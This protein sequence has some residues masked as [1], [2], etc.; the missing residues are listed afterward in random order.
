MNCNEEVIIKVLGKL[1]LTFPELEIDLPRQRKLREVLADVL[2]DYDVLTRETSLIVSDIEEKV[3]YFLSSKKLDGLSPRTLKNYRNILLKF[4]SLMKKP[5]STITTNDMRRYLAFTSQYKAGE[6][7]KEKKETSRN[8]E[9]SNLK[10][11][12]AWLQDEE[13]ILK[14]PMKKIK[15]TKV[16]K[17]LRHALSEEEV[18]ILRQA[19]KTIRE[20]S[21]LEFLL[22]TG[23]RLSEVVGVNK[24]DINWH[25]MSLSVIG[26]GNKERVVYFSPKTKILLLKYLETRKGDNEA[27]FVSDRRPHQRLGGRAIQRELKNIALRTNLDKSVFSHLM[28]HCFGSHKLNAGM[29]L[30]VLQELM[31]HESPETT[32]VYSKVSKENVKYEYKK[33]M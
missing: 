18:E 28:R 22:S 1:T 17:R 16:P 2:C 29:S 15:Q 24:R 14:D 4:A 3:G 23:C 9:I 7:I 19:C 31:G 5:I 13:Y 25:D 12:F 20:S 33:I 26:K 6:T 10:T 11:F 27:L 8:T 30:T 21:M 32:L